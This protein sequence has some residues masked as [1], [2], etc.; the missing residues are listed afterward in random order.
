M[1]TILCKVVYRV[2]SD[3]WCLI[4]ERGGGCNGGPQLYRQEHRDDRGRQRPPGAALYASA[5]SAARCGSRPAR[6][7]PTSGWRRADGTRSCLRPNGDDG[8]DCRFLLLQGVG[9][10]DFNSLLERPEATRHGK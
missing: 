7:A 2:W 10:Y 4:A 5:S 6:R 9:V 8:E 3:T 1:V